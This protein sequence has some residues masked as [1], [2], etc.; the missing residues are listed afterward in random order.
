MAL[1][2]IDLSELDALR[3]GLKEAKLEK[4]KLSKEIDELKLAHAK[5]FDD[6]KRG[7]LVIEKTPN[8]EVKH[9]LHIDKDQFI[10]R[11]LH[12][13]HTY[14]QYKPRGYEFDEYFKMKIGE[15]FRDH[16]YG[17]SNTMSHGTSNFVSTIESIRGYTEVENEIK[18]FYH[19]K[20]EKVIS[21]YKEYVDK[22][23]TYKKE[24]REKF[25]KEAEELMSKT[26]FKVKTIKDD[27]DDHLKRMQEEFDE[28]IKTLEDT[29]KAEIE[30]ITNNHK[31]DI[32]ALKP[33]DFELTELL[34][35][36][37]YELKPGNFFNKE[38]KLVKI[39]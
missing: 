36:M 33:K 26:D 25:D 8:Y 30:V 11:A 28:R 23:N 37:G 29:H 18:E 10:T 9:G 2:H 27:H 19:N 17:I 1:V 24:L 3:D 21:S 7:A 38:P 35:K 14:S 15:L 22:F 12:A 16:S 32:I 39:K 34:Q 4:E 5:E 20:Y 6:L 31:A 13:I